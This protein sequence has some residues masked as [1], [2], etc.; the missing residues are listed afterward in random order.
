[1]PDKTPFA[2]H[3]ISTPD[4]LSA[5]QFYTQCFGWTTSE[6]AMGKDGTYTM[7]SLPGEKPF[8]G[9]LEMVGEQ[10]EGVPAHWAVYVGVEDIQ[11]SVKAVQL[12][13]GKVVVPPF[14]M[15]DVGW[16]ALVQDPQ[17]ASLYLY[18]P[19]GS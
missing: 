15:D 3:E 17:G 12:A 8:G 10:W 6:M 14:E 7:F 4:G 5:K 2:W 16:T 18:Q 9:I 11:E 1:M 19:T 13:G